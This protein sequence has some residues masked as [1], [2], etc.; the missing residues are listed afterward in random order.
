MNRNRSKS[1]VDRTMPM[2]HPN[3]AAIDIGATMHMAAV[4]ADRAPEPVRSFGTFTA[5]LHRL[6]DWFTEC[7]VETVVMESTSVYWIPIFELLDARGFAVFL[8]NARDAKHVP[9]RKTDVSDAQ[10]LQR[11]HSFGLLR[12]SFRPKGQIAELRAYVRQRERLLE[13]A[14]SHIQHMQKALTEMNLQLHHVVADITGATG[15]RIIRAILAGERDP[16]A[17]AGLRHYS[18]HSSAETIAKA[19]TGSYRTE[20]LFALEQAL[21][22]YDAYH[23]KASACDVRIESVLKELIIHRGHD[24]GSAPPVSRRRNRTD[25]ANALAFDVRAALFGLLGKDVTMIDGLGPYLSLKLIAECGDDLT[26]WP[27]AKHFTSWLGLAPSNKVSG[28]KMLSSRTRRSGGRAAALLRLAAVT[29]GRTDTALGA[30]YRR[31]SSRIGKAKAVTATARKI[32]VLF[33]NAVRHGM[34]YVDPGGLVLRD[35]LPYTGDQQFAPTCQ[36]IRLCSAALGA[37]SWCCRFLGIVLQRQLP[38]L[39]VERLHVDGRR[40]R[41]RA[42]RSKNLGSPTLQLRLPRRYLIGVDVEVLGQLSHRS[43]ALDGSERHLSL[44]SRCVVPARLSAHGLSCSRRLSPLSGRN[45]TYR[46]VQISGAGS[47]PSN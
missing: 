45:S 35:T 38:D 2:V 37:E 19:L 27:S 44:E 17:L 20:H 11:L 14:A 43:V 46:P 47:E 3:A 33:Y 34:D 9:G 12:A 13:Y 1:R 18:C 25:Q 16:E 15:L 42:P 21:S 24:H 22:L 39:G 36:D 31:L 23:E 26:S 28:G 6:V 4:R 7:G 40:G 5:D 10:W 29:V 30:F 8:V 41:R 32:A